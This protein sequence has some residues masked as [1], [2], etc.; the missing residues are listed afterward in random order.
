M[1]ASGPDR[2][3]ISAIGS[4]ESALCLVRKSW[5][6]V[7]PGSE[8]W[9]YAWSR[10]AGWSTSVYSLGGSNRPRGGACFPKKGGFFPLLGVSQGFWPKTLE[11]PVFT[12]P[13]PWKPPK[14]PKN[15]HFL[16]PK[17]GGSFGGVL[18]GVFGPPGGMGGS[19]RGFGQKP[20]N[21][22]T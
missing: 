4:T 16:T 15:G 3:D 18:G 13:D 12:P 8:G 6:T 9:R 19:F 21:P 5:Q 17:R 20:E 2:W 14:T 22:P 10:A 7:Q 1:V 11:N